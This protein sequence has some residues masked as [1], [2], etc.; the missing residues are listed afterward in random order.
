MKKFSMAVIAVWPALVA[1]GLVT[2]AHIRHEESLAKW[3]E[4]GL[5][6]GGIVATILWIKLLDRITSSRRT[7]S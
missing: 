5:I 3:V 7:Q 4:V 1:W 2:V 6:L